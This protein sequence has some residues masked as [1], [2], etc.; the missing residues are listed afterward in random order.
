MKISAMTWVAITTLFL[1]MLTVA[2]ALGSAFRWIFLA[3]V[4]GQALV[5][6]MVYKVLRD[7]W[8]TDKT[9]EDYYEDFPVPRE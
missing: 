7:S 5:L 2:A 1:L 3:T 4:A 8:T 9:F 6:I